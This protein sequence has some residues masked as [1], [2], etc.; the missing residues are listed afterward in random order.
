MELE[1]SCPAGRNVKI[2]QMLWKEVW[3]FLEKPNTE[4]P[5][6]LGHPGCIVITRGIFKQRL[7][8]PVSLAASFTIATRREQ[9]KRPSTGGEM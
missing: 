1:P 4:L 3:G 9:P 6:D 5:Q 7:A 8:P 2:I